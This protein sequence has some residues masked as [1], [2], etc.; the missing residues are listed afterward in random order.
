MI[1][2]DNPKSMRNALAV[3][4]S[5]DHWAAFQPKRPRAVP[6][7][8]SLTRLMRPEMPSPSRSSGSE[9]SIRAASGTLSSS[10]LPCTAGATRPAI[11]VV[12]AS[13]P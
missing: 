9:S 6:P 4:T 10:P 5:S 3:C 13:G 1:P 2:D 8:K 11:N 12:S 7:S